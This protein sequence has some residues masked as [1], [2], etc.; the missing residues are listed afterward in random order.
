MVHLYA[1]A[2]GVLHSE[3]ENHF[4][5]WAGN[6]VDPMVR[7]PGI[8]VRGSFRAIRS[9]KRDADLRFALDLVA[10]DVCCHSTQLSTQGSTAFDNKLVNEKGQNTRYSRTVVK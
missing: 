9:R 6:E 3:S 8:A 7:G 4:R 10:F 2:C 1:L 5:P